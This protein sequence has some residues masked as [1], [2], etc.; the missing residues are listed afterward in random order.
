LYA[1]V[2]PFSYVQVYWG[3]FV[4][5]M[6]LF[7]VYLGLAI[8]YRADLLGLQYAIGIVIFLFAIE[9]MIWGIGLSVYNH[10]GTTCIHY[11]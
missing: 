9:Q 3:L 8:Y 4:A 2:A 1:F 11:H 7:L 5:L 6:I 10:T